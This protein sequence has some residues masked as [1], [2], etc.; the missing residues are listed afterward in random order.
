MEDCRK[1]LEDRYGS[2][3]DFKDGNTKEKLLFVIATVNEY[4]LE[5]ELSE[6]FKTNPNATPEDLYQHMRMYWLPVIV[7]SDEEVNWDAMYEYEDRM[8]E[9]LSRF[10]TDEK[11]RY[12]VWEDLLFASM[13]R[14]FMKKMEEYVDE[15]P[16]A[17]FEELKNQCR[18]LSREWREGL[19]S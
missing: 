14:Q 13:Q 15:H 7:V 5:D 9:K 17:S 1:F 19:S 11:S 3:A 2:L 4:E 10:I 18:Q 6:Y 8:I 12:R 16:Q